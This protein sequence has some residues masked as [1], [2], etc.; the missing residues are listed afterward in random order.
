M[1]NFPAPL[2]QFQQF[3]LLRIGNYTLQEW[4][5]R[6]W[7]KACLF[8]F[9]A[10]IVTQKDLSF[11]VNM[12][13]VDA[14][15]SIGAPSSLANS[16]TTKHPQK[17]NTDNTADN[18]ADNTS[19]IAEASVGGGLLELG[20]GSKAAAKGSRSTKSAAVG[21]TMSNLAPILNPAYIKKHNIDPILVNQKMEVCREY[22]KAHAPA[23]VRE[24]HSYSIPASI[25]LAQGLLESNAGSSNL[26]NKANNHFGI[27]CFSKTCKNGHCMNA[28][29]DT[30]KDFFRISIYPNPSV[31]GQFT[32]QFSAKPATSVTIEITDVIG[33]VID[34][35]V[36]N[37][38]TV[39][40]DKSS[41]APG[42]YYLSAR[43]KE[44]MLVKKLVIQ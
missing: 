17:T 38:E 16:H 41:L 11:S 13:N 1:Q 44:M 6:H 8:L 18:I 43:N 22:V 40:L 29:D 31:D 42:V 19:E 34:H 39:V 30:H 25:T 9:V 32:L 12:R 24:M 23:A 2:Q 35:F 27:K 4:F 10:Y 20:A 14:D 5:N 36:V 28:T 3:R 33:K 15:T 21:N 37:D 26:A 7:L